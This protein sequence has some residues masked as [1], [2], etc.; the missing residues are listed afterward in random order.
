MKLKKNQKQKKLLAEKSRKRILAHSSTQKQATQ[1]TFTIELQKLI[2]SYRN[3]PNYTLI[4]LVENPTLFTDFIIKNNETNSFFV[5]SLPTHASIANSPDFI[6]NIKN[7]FEQFNP[8]LIPSR[9][10][11]QQ[12]TPVSND[13]H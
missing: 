11:I 2:D 6:Q 4:P 1:R 12:L 10:I 13:S 5:I 7:R 3:N 9:I 8:S